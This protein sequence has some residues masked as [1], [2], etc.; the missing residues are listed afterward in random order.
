MAILFVLTNFKFRKNKRRLSLRTGGR[1][2]P[3]TFPKLRLDVA[4]KISIRK[5]VSCPKSLSSTGTVLAS[6]SPHFFLNVLIINRSSY[7]NL[8]RYCSQSIH[9]KD[10]ILS[11]MTNSNSVSTQSCNAAT[12][13]KVHFQ[14]NCV[15]KKV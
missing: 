13:A 5:F 6:I 4:Q 11:E 12:G 15:L 14:S 9:F 2:L 8:R 1:I 10:Y 7:I 3:F